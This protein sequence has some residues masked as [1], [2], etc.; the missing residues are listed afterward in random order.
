MSTHAPNSLAN[1]SSA[2]LRSAMH[3]PT[4]WHEWGAEAFALAQAQDKPILLDVGAVWC[5]WCHVMDRESYE[6]AETAA[7]LN[8]HFICIKVDRDERPDVDARY[9]A[10]VASITGQGGWPLTVFLTPDGKMFFG[11]TYFPPV[12]SYGRAGFGRVLLA[13][14]EAFRDR[15]TELEIESEELM[16]QLA[17]AE[18]LPGQRG[19]FSAAIVAKMVQSAL[20]N[21]DR[22]NGGF[23]DAPKFS[24]PAMMDLLLDWYARTGEKLVGRV[25]ETT[26]EKMA[27]GGVYDQLAGGFH[28]YSVDERWCVPHF[29]KMAYDNSELLKNY[30]HAWQATG[31]PL[32]AEVARDILRW[33]REWLSDR[34]RGGYYGSQ[35]ADIDLHDDGSY[36]TWTLEEARAVLTAEELAVAA[37]HYDIGEQGEMPHEPEKNVLWVRETVEQIAARQGRT[38]EATAQLLAAAKKKL[39]AAR[40]LRPTPFVD[41]TLYTG[42]NALCISAVLQAGRVLGDEAELQFALRSLERL[43]AEAYLPDGGLRHVI[44]YAEDGANQKPAGVLDDYAY[45]TLACLDAYEASG[46]LRYYERAG[47]IAARMI[48]GF[49]DDADGGFFDLDNAS[50]QDTV[51]ALT[52]RRKPFRDSPTPAGDPAAALALLRLHALN[53]DAE[54]RN[55]ARE[56]LEVSGGVI[57]QYGIFG[58]SYG[59][60]AVW[61]ARPHTQVVVVGQGPMAEVLLAEAL[62]GFALGK[63]VLRVKDAAAVKTALPAALAETIVAVPA[64]QDGRAVALLCSGF[65][66]Q[67]PMYTAEELRNAL[68]EAVTHGN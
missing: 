33:M 65:T 4:A 31:N 53:G 63:I 54:L 24:Y 35:D 8:Q 43:L 22:E 18:S 59:V 47:G 1:A 41:R 21:F 49:H 32:F 16:H 23:G 55:L 56:T 10:A 30:V 13:I 44:A 5:H 17:R 64:V 57:E 50:T 26:M 51:G 19:E 29:E 67:P 37:A 14:A 58:G 27:R 36:F 25:I 61:L 2:Y 12:D 39:Y 9:Q 7:I 68:K 38:V 52:S 40:L 11:G 45:T 3:Q 66:C 46:E 42:W 34:E 6:S 48:A 60:A 20:G 15:R 28:R 62:A